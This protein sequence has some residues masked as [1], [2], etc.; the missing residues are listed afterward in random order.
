MV[1]LSKRPGL[2]MMNTYDRNHAQE[3]ASSQ[4]NP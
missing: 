1:V 3:H 4:G 2:T